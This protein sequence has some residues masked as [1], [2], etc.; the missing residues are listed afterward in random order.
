M[1]FWKTVKKLFVSLFLFPFMVSPVFSLCKHSTCSVF[2]PFR[3]KLRAPFPHQLQC[4]PALDRC[5]FSRAWHR[6]AFSVSLDTGARFPALSSDWLISLFRLLWW[7]GLVS[8][9]RH[10]LHNAL[11]NM[12]CFP[13]FRSLEVRDSA[14]RSC[15]CSCA[16]FT[17]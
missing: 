10:S 1:K 5:M 17:I 7:S 13:H 15:S 11:N 16:G 12:F 14:E 9:V 8:I 4:F 2:Q 3:E 6:C